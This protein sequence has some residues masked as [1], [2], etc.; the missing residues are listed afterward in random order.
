MNLK[1]LA[2][3]ALT[4]GM[5]A[6]ASAAG[7]QSPGLQF[8]ISF[9]APAHAGPITGRVFV[10]P[11]RTDDTEPRFQMG[12]T[13]VPFFGRDISR[14]SAG[15][16]AVIDATD[17]GSP[18][19]SLNDLPPGDYFAQAMI[20][21]Y[22]E[23]KRADGHIVWMHDDQWEGQLWTRS[24]GNL[25]GKVEKVH[26]DPKAVG[27]QTVT[28]VASDVIPAITV[29]A[30]TEWVKRFKIQSPTLTKFLG[31]AHLYRPDRS[32]TERFTRAPHSVVIYEQGH[33]QLEAPMGFRS[34]PPTE[35]ELK[36]AGP[37]ARFLKRG[38]ELYQAWTAD[39]F[40]RLIVV[41]FQHPNP[42]FDDSY[43]VNSVNVG[44]YGDSV[45]QE[46]IP[47]I[48]KRFRTIKEPYARILTGGS[49]GGWEALALQIFHPDFWRHLGILPGPGDVLERRG[50]QLL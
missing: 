46:L 21:V 20:S 31:T 2:I 35:A 10:I 40:P 12:R 1:R 48:E 8:K 16:A 30:D 44:P 29:P 23:F 11:S 6:V 14:L 5:L 17:L 19:E 36:E 50:D 24:P 22:S 37:G 18:V 45:M 34:E 41:T 49:T 26:L 13:G 42:Y 25:K 27:G 3:G 43:A 39:N 33:F 38:Y 4:F 47:E 32:T 28:L 9:P 15:E 7:A